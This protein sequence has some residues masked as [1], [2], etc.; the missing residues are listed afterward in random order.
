MVT[1]NR[2]ET[3]KILSSVVARVYVMNL[4]AFFLISRVWMCESQ[5]SWVILLFENTRIQGDKILDPGIFSTKLTIVGV[6]QTF[7][8]TKRIFLRTD[9]LKPRLAYGLPFA[10][11]CATV[12]W[13]FKSL[14]SS[15]QMKRIWGLYPLSQPLSTVSR[16]F[17]N[18]STTYENLK[19][20]YN[21]QKL[22]WSR[23][24]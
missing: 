5:W 13:Y 15:F 22:R 24:A 17:G 8:L 23:C 10:A 6:R 16:R 20:G 11:H 3:S 7:P 4:A 1:G 12:L 19:S 2:S 14:L 18:Y 21:H 9:H